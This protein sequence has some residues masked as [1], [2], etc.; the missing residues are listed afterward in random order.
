MKSDFLQR[1]PSQADREAWRA[2]LAMPPA[3]RSTGL[4]TLFVVR[5]GD[6]RI[7]LDPAVVG[8]VM[9]E[10]VTHSI[11]HR[12]AAL[13]G[14]AN[15]RGAL[16]LCFSLRHLLGCDREAESGQGMWMV[17]QHRGWRVACRIDAAIGM[18]AYDP[19]SRVEVPATMRTPATARVA[20]MF[21]DP[22]IG[23]VAWLDADSLF[24]AFE[25]VAR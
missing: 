21:P 19:N 20:A 5:C 16:T 2:Q 14:L 17:L 24:N 9:P 3:V 12:G 10:G 8:L 22:Q 13:A 18:R 7:G 15:V 4:V 23:D 1:E 6:E 11:P 25:N